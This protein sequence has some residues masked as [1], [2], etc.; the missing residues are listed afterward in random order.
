[1]RVSEKL[2]LVDKIGRALQAKFTF[3]EIDAFLA[4]YRIA[5]IT[6]WQGNNRWAYSKA[7]LQGVNTDVLLS[8]AEE[9]E[10]PVPSARRGTSVAP[11]NW[12]DTS[13][14]RLFIS[15]VSNEKDKA[16]RLKDCLAPYGISGFVA[17]DDIHPTLEWQGEIERALY[18]MDAFI[19][20]HTVGFSASFWTQQEIGFAVARGVKIISIKMGEDPTGF[21]S[22][23]QALPRRQRTAEQIAEEVRSLLEGD[24]RTA[25]RL[26]AA[27]PTMAP[28]SLDDDIPF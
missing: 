8:I 14:L 7:A 3:A 17:H 28:A 27:K 4:E 24:E 16:K 15:H 13:L 12:K 1:M 9:L 18:A 23:H 6:N 11:R 22:K 26:A 20:L 21:I 19:A 10:V 2:D 25:P 5:S